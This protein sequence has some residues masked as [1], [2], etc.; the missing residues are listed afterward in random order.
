[1]QLHPP[2]EETIAG[3]AQSLRERRRTCVDVV[4]GCLAQ[5]EIWEPKVHAW[6]S[7]DRKGALASARRLD[8]ELAIGKWRGPLHGIPIGIKD[9]VDVKGWPTAA[10][11][12]WLANAL[13]AV[14]API[15]ERLRAAGAIIL[16]K[17]V[18]TQFACFDPP[19]TRNPWNLERT[20]GGSSSGSAAA[21]ATG[22]CLGAI[23]SQTGGSITRPA[24]FCGIAGCKPSFG[25]VPLAGVYPLSASLDHPGPLARSVE[26]LAMLLEA[27]VDPSDRARFAGIP[28][29][30]S[31]RIGRIRGMFADRA[32]PL[33]WAAF[34]TALD[35]FAQAGATVSD[36]TLPPTFDDVL[37]C[38]RI[39]MISELAEN[40]RSSLAAHAADY[41]PGIRCL[42]EDGLQ[43]DK[44]EYTRCQAHQ[45]A[46]KRE[47]VAAFTDVDVLACPSAVGPAPTT[48]ST[49]D[50]SFNA[51]WSYT[52][53]PTVSFPIGLAP[54]GLPLAIQL[55]GRAHEER[56]LLGVAAWCERCVAYVGV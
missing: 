15:V 8:Q 35:R 41:L 2:Q 31:V 14:D 1:M 29:V 54:D 7:V 13:V 16:G 3:V 21:V 44:Q 20:P 6:V 9:L 17:T 49:G 40:H 51:P 36:V 24:S 25:L 42:I 12:P 4:A 26:D 53:L 23:G 52:G 50:P 37:R 28:N 30:K 11:A 5:I 10:G 46:L 38:H 55:V 48:E 27:I 43:V 39:I 18:T 47:I 56:K 45:Q 34:E 33:A 22:M 19:P 32:E